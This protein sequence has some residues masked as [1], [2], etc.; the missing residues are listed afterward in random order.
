[1]SAFLKVYT[2]SGHTSEV[3]HTTQNATTIAT[4][5]AV[6]AGDTTVQLTSTSGMPTQGYI[7]V[8]DGTNGNE[9]LAYYGLSGNVI[10]ISRT[11]GFQFAHAA[12]LTVNQWYY[13]LAV[14]DQT[15][16]IANDGSN[17]SPNGSTNVGTWYL[18]NSGDQTAQSPSIATASGAPSTTSGYSDTLVSITSISAGFATSVSPSN[19]AAA[20]Q[21]QFWVAAEIPSGQS[22]AGNPQIC[23]INISYN[24]I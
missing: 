5:H 4:S 6:S 16:G 8:I 23:A 9:T 1:M 21:Q 22:A 24:S 13:S 2:D 3:A 15:N 10:N 20:G 14:G 12:G 17:A 19:I 7:D 11:G 18:Y